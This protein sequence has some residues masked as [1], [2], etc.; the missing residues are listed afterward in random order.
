MWLKI[1]LRIKVFFKSK[2]PNSAVIVDMHD[3]VNKMKCDM[4]ISEA[5]KANLPK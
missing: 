1:F 4:R 5:I 3:Y 2:E